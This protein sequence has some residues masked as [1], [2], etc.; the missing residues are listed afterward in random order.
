MF[1][2]PRFASC[3][4]EFST[5]YPLPGGFPHSEIRGSKGAGPSPQLIAACHVLHRLSKPRHPPDALKTLDRE[6]SRAGTNPTHELSHTQFRYRSENSR[7]DTQHI[8]TL[9][10]N[11]TFPRINPGTCSNPDMK[12][13]PSAYRAQRCVRPKWWR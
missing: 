2:F 4:Y 3:T 8:F 5:R 12:I 11:P 13:I 6:T 7:F 1:Q 10:K 9:S